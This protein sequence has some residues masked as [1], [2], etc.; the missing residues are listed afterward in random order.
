MTDTKIDGYC[1]MGCGPTLF[2]GPSGRV[3]CGRLECPRPDAV[4]TLL[5]ERETEHVVVFSG[6]AFTVR[7][8]LYERLDDVLMDCQLHH[9]IAALDGPPV[10]PGRYRALAK[11]GVWTWESVSS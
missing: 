8:P 6:E 4:A 2:A 9:H 1:P 10:E 5:E 11:Y 3:L 7:H